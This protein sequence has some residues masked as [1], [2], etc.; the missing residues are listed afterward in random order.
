M[1]KCKN[2]LLDFYPGHFRSWADDLYSSTGYVSALV[3]FL[4]DLADALESGKVVESNQPCKNCGYDGSPCPVCGKTD[5]V[6]C[7]G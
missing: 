5:H 2:T 3:K 4:R 1:G 7:D 6:N